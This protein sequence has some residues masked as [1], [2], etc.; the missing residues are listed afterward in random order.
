MT[1]IQ[2]RSAVGGFLRGIRRPGEPGGYSSSG[3]LSPAK[4]FTYLIGADVFASP[5]TQDERA[6]VG[7][8]GDGNVGDPRAWVAATHA[9]IAR[10]CEVFHRTLVIMVWDPGGRVIE[11]VRFGLLGWPGFIFWH[12][13]LWQ[14][15]RYTLKVRK[16]AVDQTDVSDLPLFCH[17]LPVPPAPSLGATATISI[18]SHNTRG[19]SPNKLDAFVGLL[20]GCGSSLV[21]GC[22][23]E[24]KRSLAIAAPPFKVASTRAAGKSGTAGGTAVFYP[25]NLNVFTGQLDVRRRGKGSADAAVSGTSLHVLSTDS[26]SSL[27]TVTSVYISSGVSKDDFAQA[28][29]GLG[30]HLRSGLEKGA[31]INLV[32]GDF[33]VHDDR[34]VA[35]HNLMAGLGYSNVPTGPTFIIPASGRRPASESTL[36]LVFVLLPAGASCSVEVIKQQS[37]HH[38]LLLR[39][40]G[41]ARP[42]G[43]APPLIPV[44]DADRLRFPSRA[45]LALAKAKVAR[46]MSGS[47][48]GTAP[49]SLTR[50]I[51]V[52]VEAVATVRYP[53]VAAARGR[54]FKG[55]VRTPFF[56]PAMELLQRK[57]EAS[58]ASLSRFRFFRDRGA[59][60]RLLESTRLLRDR[61]HGLFK[62][63]QERFNET[64]LSSL[65][66]RDVR[67]VRDR[68]GVPGRRS[69]AAASVRHPMDSY[70]ELQRDFGSEPQEVGRV[71]RLAMVEAYI[72]GA[73]T[74]VN[75]ICFF[76]SDMAFTAAEIS[77]AATSLSRSASNG[78]DGLSRAMLIL[79]PPAWYAAVASLAT[80]ITRRGI[81]PVDFLLS[82]ASSIPKPKDAGKFRVVCNGPTLAKLI[83]VAILNRMA[84]NETIDPSVFFG[85]WQVGFQRSHGA[86]EPQMVLEAFFDM[87]RRTGT[88]AFLGACDIT[89]AFDSVSQLAI[90]ERAVALGLTPICV[91]FLASYLGII[92][93]GFSPRRMRVVG[94]EGLEVI[95][96]HG[97]PCGMVLSP[98]LYNLG[99]RAIAGDVDPGL[100]L[101]IPPP[102][103]ILGVARREALSVAGV[104]YA[105]D[106]CVLARDGPGVTRALYGS[107]G[108][109]GLAAS[110]ARLNQVVH[111]KKFEAFS[112]LGP[113]VGREMRVTGSAIPATS[114]IRLLGA[115][116]VCPGT[117]VQTGMALYATGAKAYLSDDR[118]PIQ[119]RIRHV[120]TVLC[121]K[122]VYS[123]LTMGAAPDRSLE[124]GFH[125]AL[126]TVVGAVIETPRAHLLAFLGIRDIGVYR[127]YLMCLFALYSSRSQ[128]LAQ[129][130]SFRR[131]MTM[132]WRLPGRDLQTFSGF[133]ISVFEAFDPDVAGFTPETRVDS[134]PSEFMQLLL[135]DNEEKLPAGPGF[136]R[137]GVK[138]IFGRAFDRA[139]GRP[140]IPASTIALGRFAGPY[141]AFA[142]DA[143]LRPAGGVVR[144]AG[145]RPV[146]CS[147][148]WGAMDDSPSHLVRCASA[149]AHIHQHL[150][151][152]AGSDNRL[153]QD[154]LAGLH[155]TPLLFDPSDS[156]VE[157]GET[158]LALL[159]LRALR[160]GEL[161]FMV[162]PQQGRPLPVSVIEVVPGQYTVPR[163]RHVIDTGAVDHDPPAVVAPRCRLDLPYVQL[164]DFLYLRKLTL[165]SPRIGLGQVPLTGGVVLATGTGDPSG[166]GRAV[167]VLCGLD[168][169]V[170]GVSRLCSSVAAWTVN[171]AAHLVAD[172]KARDLFPM[173]PRRKTHT[174]AAHYADLLVTDV[175][176]GADFAVWL[177]ASSTG[178]SIKV[179]DFTPRADVGSLRKTLHPS[180]IIRTVGSLDGPW[181]GTLVVRLLYSKRSWSAVVHG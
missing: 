116:H 92:E 14:G 164:R 39:I 22:S 149:L 176:G 119:H 10:W 153:T 144:L 96:R 158:A 146:L 17:K 169:T 129:G 50:A 168:S 61:F 8:L 91:R 147:F 13:G 85:P 52:G 16:A 112:S 173:G 64:L 140:K 163:S 2:R 60:R 55:A 136:S 6:V 53:G 178:H 62:A 65:D 86:M 67:A 26:A 84:K 1:K 115:Y 127:R 19:L 47:D 155:G 128:L 110:L 108:F 56:T 75:P 160:L 106:T 150:P 40:Y 166:L 34:L 165:H 114:A 101:I 74:P 121:P 58:E 15:G 122:S 82:V 59:T 46:V 63:A 93:L 25:P 97:T 80:E 142:S 172:A 66:H 79:P 89:R 57:I 132:A 37:D 125:E 135:G 7:R 139:E 137:K 117:S 70:C 123:T 151:V 118:H 54:R 102:P 95:S 107:P 3:F 90:L 72:N 104:Q 9:D 113:G 156:T 148:C 43:R 78:S 174:N 77:E 161:D 27:M 38:A 120:S 98:L 111:E 138:S 51:F 71:E 24:T 141:F 29:A 180:P 162:V 124:R 49:D 105:D 177:M 81:W 21:L 88:E 73:A 5:L 99:V 170:G 143:Y 83:E 41:A 167:A 48:Y 130:Q 31:P 181:L 33:N 134:T 32:L 28:L 159:E 4:N 23:Q 44:V 175:G 76:G 68:L 18:V 126:C 157:V 20:Q 87:C 154:R 109:I 133:L 45:L 145:S 131:L 179:I 103:D 12:G 94:L 42:E 100:G 171:H 36:D 69:Q 152:S 35:L 11:L 30:T